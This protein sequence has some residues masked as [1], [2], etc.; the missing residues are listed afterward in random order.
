MSHPHGRPETNLCLHSWVCGFQL[1]WHQHFTSSV[2]L[3]N[4]RDSTR[5]SHLLPPMWCL[6]SD[7]P[8]EGSACHRH[9]TRLGIHHCR[10]FLGPRFKASSTRSPRNPN[11]DLT[12]RNH[13][14]IDVCDKP[15]TTWHNLANSRA[16]PAVVTSC[17]SN[18]PQ[19]DVLVAIGTRS[20]AALDPTA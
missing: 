10:L 7:S 17:M 11:R 8:W 15:S 19:H 9:P 2:G 14:R 13:S 12:V 3:T 6:G 16:I 4:T 1:V 20:G 18:C 5:H